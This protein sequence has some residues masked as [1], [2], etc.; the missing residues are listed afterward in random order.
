M[1]SRAATDGERLFLPPYRCCGVSTRKI[2]LSTPGVGGYS[3]LCDVCARSYRK[4]GTRRQNNGRL[5]K[6]VGL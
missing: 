2:R 1:N 3:Y 5:V 4:D 6:R